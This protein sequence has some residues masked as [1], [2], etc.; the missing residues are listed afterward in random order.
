MLSGIFCTL[1]GSL[2]TQFTYILT[3]VEED[4]CN[5]PGYNILNVLI[6]LPN[7]SYIFGQCLFNQMSK[8]RGAQSHLG[9]LH[10]ILEHTLSTA[11]KTESDH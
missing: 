2:K 9:E 5:S 10:L 7:L 6:E 3:S 11:N 8:I 4:N 1:A